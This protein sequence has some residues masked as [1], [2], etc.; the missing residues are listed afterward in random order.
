MEVKGHGLMGDTLHQK[1][2]KM[3]VQLFAQ[4]KPT[5]KWYKLRQKCL[6]MHQIFYI[7]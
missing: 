4:T 7:A 1:I 3:L 5:I 6:D 2:C